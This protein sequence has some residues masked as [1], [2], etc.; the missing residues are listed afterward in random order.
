MST[1][2]ASDLLNVALSALEASKDA[3]RAKWSYLH[4]LDEK[5]H[6][7]TTELNVAYS[8]SGVRG[9]WGFIP[10]RVKGLESRL[11]SLKSQRSMCWEAVKEL[12]ADLDLK[13]AELFILRA[14]DNSQRACDNSKR[15]REEVEDV[16]QV[17]EKF[18]KLDIAEEEVSAD[19]AAAEAAAVVEAEI[20]TFI[21]CDVDCKNLE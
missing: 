8:E 17:D 1:L 2:E 11:H 3:W 16:P 19:V 9:G 6:E 7:V 21:A 10:P 14:C 15:K 20:C 5:I 12:D 13:M 18:R 4:A